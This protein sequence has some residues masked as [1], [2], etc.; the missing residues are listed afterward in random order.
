MSRRP[1][2]VD[3]AVLLVEPSRR[4]VTNLR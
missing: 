1:D 2:E 4:L 3:S